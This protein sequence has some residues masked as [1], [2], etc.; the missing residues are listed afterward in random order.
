MPKAVKCTN[1]LHISPVD[2]SIHLQRGTQKTVS[3]QLLA[4]PVD[5]IQCNTYIQTLVI[6]LLSL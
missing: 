1:N 6:M 5:M 3:R 4:H 2:Y